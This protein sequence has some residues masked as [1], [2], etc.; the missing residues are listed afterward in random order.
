ML[1]KLGKD[2]A[3]Y[4][5]VDFLFRFTQLLAV[6]IYAFSLSLSEFGILSLLTVSATLLGM[7]I[8]LGVG[9]A[10]QRFYFDPDL[11]EHRRPALVSGGFVQL[12]VVGALVSLVALLILFPVS[13][14]LDADL[15]ISWPLILC[16]V[17]IALPEQLSQY[18][19]DAVRLQFA[20]LRFCAISL[21]KNFGAVLVGLLLLIEFDMGVM[22]LL[23]G[24]V[25]A[26]WL[27][28]PVGLLMIRRNLT[29]RLDSRLWG[30]LLR[31]GSPFVLAGAAYWVFGSVG[32][33]ML[34]I[35]GT[36][37]DVGLFAIGM[38]FS[39]VMTFIISA[40]AQAWSPYALRMYGEDPDYR[41]KWASV[42]SVWMF[43]LA[44]ASLG[45]ALFAPELMRLL[46][47][48]EYWPAAR[49]LAIGAV[50]LVFYGTVQMTSLGVMIAKRTIL[51]N[52]A[53]WAAAVVA[54]VLN[55]LLIPRFGGVGA[56]V[57]TLAAYVVLTSI[58]LFWTQRLH[59]MPLEYGRLG[60][61][62]LLVVAALVGGSIAAG[63]EVGA[64]AFMAKGLV[65]LAA[66]GGAFAIGIVDR[67]LYRMLIPR[68]A[69]RPAGEDIP[70]HG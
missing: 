56:A 27:A 8:G 29:L 38:K 23:L 7:L 26:G 47:P 37:A 36:A 18:L 15:G 33:W 46:T 42:F 69:S 13:D 9:N 19:L 35:Y 66:I 68:L 57:A 48:P 53:A 39:V 22:G 2:V 43:V 64:V 52:Y 10:V 3:I 59:P 63:V 32:N 31:Y 51:L 55:L 60:Y 50:G 20:P 41:E 1:T 16:A 30:Q 65:L 44:L 28:V 70:R 11:G 4:G 25:I 61:G 14:Q 6:P 62:L 40:F 17:A 21:V 67:G 54:V 12:L 24:I 49:V 5:G 58:L 34:G 45:L